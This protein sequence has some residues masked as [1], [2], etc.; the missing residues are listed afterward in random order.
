M[1]EKSIKIFENAEQNR[2]LNVYI[3]ITLDIQNSEDFI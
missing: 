2:I 1:D 3:D